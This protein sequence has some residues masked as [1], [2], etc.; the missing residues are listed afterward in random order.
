M[1]VQQSQAGSIIGRAGFK[2]KNLRETTNTF[3]KVF[4]D[5]LPDS[6]ERIVAIQGPADRIVHAVQ[7]ICET[8]RETPV[9]GSVNLYDPS[10]VGAFHDYS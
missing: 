1:L 3:I 4:S 9:K 8:L 10:N 7:L 5:C 6:T 2:I